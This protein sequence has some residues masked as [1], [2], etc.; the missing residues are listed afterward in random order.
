M[1]KLP[2]RA[3]RDH[4][5]TCMCACRRPRSRRGWQRSNLR[6]TKMRATNC[7]GALVRAND[8]LLTTWNYSGRGHDRLCFALATELGE[9]AR[10]VQT[11]FNASKTS[12]VPSAQASEDEV[13]ADDGEDEVASSEDELEEDGDVEMAT[14]DGATLTVKQQEREA[15]KEA[16]AA[17]KQAAKDRKAVQ[18]SKLAARKVG[19]DS[20]KASFT[21]GPPVF[22]QASADGRL[23]QAVLLPAW[24]NRPFFPLLQ[25]Q[26]GFR[27]FHCTQR[28]NVR[29]RKSETRILPRCWKRPRAP[30]RSAK[31]RGLL[32]LAR[33]VANRKRKR[34]PS[35][36]M[37]RRAR[38]TR[39]QPLSLPSPQLVSGA[40]RSVMP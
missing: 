38:T 33:A 32:Q 40:H 28:I 15:K 9:L 14:G 10:N 5:L 16:R 13:V 37:T 1:V 19:V 39:M 23:D 31:G 26:G 20:K 8:A 36:S 34:T 22:S 29:H 24:P 6:R 27:C 2:L 30:S 25:P 12:A 35:C 17:A 4:R 18:Y 3:V 11:T 21:L 7:V